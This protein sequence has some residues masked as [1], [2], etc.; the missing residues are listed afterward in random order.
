MSS[1]DN[2][3]ATISKKG[4]LAP[5]NRFNVIFS[6]PA[7]AISALMSGDMNSLVGALNPEGAIASLASGNFDPRNALPDPRDITYLC[8]S[9]NL[10]G[11]SVSTFDHGDTKQTNKYPYTFI[12]EDVTMTFI[13][14]NDYY[15]KN[16]MDRWMS[17]IFDTVNYQAGYKSDYSTDIIIQ[18]LDQNM[19]PVYGVKLQKAYPV[20]IAPIS[21]DNNGSGYQKLTVT[22]SYDTFVAE[23]PLSSTASAAKAVIPG[24]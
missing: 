16:M 4:G 22:F 5:V 23:G 12:D 19:I 11:R 9:V 1:I 8:E 10:P 20:S 15:M 24:L 6:P 2:L 14:T 3:K 18:Q 13:L 21:L 7:G 17:S